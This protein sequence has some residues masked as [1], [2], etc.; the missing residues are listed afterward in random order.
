LLKILTSGFFSKDS[1]S[2]WA[3]DEYYKLIEKKEGK[4]EAN[5]QLE[6]LGKNNK[7]NAG[8]QRY[9]AERK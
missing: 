6:E 1:L 7:D 9:L 4:E 5:K 8:L 3:S 2:Y